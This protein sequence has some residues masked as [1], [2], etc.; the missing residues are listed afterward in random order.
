MV[1]QAALSAR[2][3][4]QRIRENIPLSEAMQFEVVSLQPNAIEVVAPLEPNI[5]I[6]G[7][8]FAGSLYSLAV[9]TAW[10]MTS[11]IVSETG[12]CADVV[13]RSADIK[14]RLPVKT[15]IRCE[16]A[17]LPEEK[18]EFIEGLRSKGK[19]RLSLSVK[20]GDS[21]EALL[22]ASMVAVKRL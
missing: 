17:C 7:T 2:E 8:G 13:V 16:C 15:D 19:G 20:I 14:Y 4:T 18:A 22:N 5:N 21:G 9:L 1:S 11:A 3:L 12:V 6:H 10:G